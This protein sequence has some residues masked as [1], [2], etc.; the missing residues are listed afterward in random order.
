MHRD[1]TDPYERAVFI[2]LLALNAPLFLFALLRIYQHSR[3]PKPYTPILVFYAILAMLLVARMVYFMDVF[4]HFSPNIYFALDLLPVSLIF[5][6]GS[7]VAYL[8]YLV[9]RREITLRFHH[10]GLTVAAKRRCFLLTL[11]LNAT[12]L[13]SFLFAFLICV[14]YSPNNTLLSFRILDI[15]FC[16]VTITI[17]TITGREVSQAIISILHRPTPI[18]V[19][20]TQIRVVKYLTTSTLCLRALINACFIAIEI[21]VSSHLQGKLP[22]GCWAL[23]VFVFYFMFETVLMMSFLIAIYAQMKEK[24]VQRQEH[25]LAMSTNKSSTSESTF[26]VSKVFNSS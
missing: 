15:C 25:L 2:L 22:K 20:P 18:R 21:T 8:W 5:C 26:S 10:C 23:I 12:V 4:W 7:I 17:L 13:F 16:I 9:L 3:S 24:K 19:T 14:I 11:F 6:A 1:D